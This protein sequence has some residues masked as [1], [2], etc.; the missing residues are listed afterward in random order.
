[1][2][3]EETAAV[4][5]TA[6]DFTLVGTQGDEIREFTLSEFAAD[7]PAVVVFYIYDYSP[8]CTDQL[9][10]LNDVEFLTFNDD[11]AVLGVSTDGPYSH[12]EFVADNDLTYPLLTDDDKRV[13]ERYGMLDADGGPRRGIVLVDGDRTVR[14]RWVAEDNWDPWTVGPLS[15]AAELAAELTA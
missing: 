13:Y 4:G 9:C 11:V 2:T 6:P 14:Y 10:E 12:R 8:V 15:E 7:R 3:G 5:D 1:M